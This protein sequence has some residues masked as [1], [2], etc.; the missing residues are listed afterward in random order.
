MHGLYFHVL[1]LGSISLIGMDS[2]DD[3]IRMD[4][5]TLEELERILKNSSLVFETEKLN[6]IT[7]SFASEG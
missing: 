5:S 3:S 7:F 6:F 1:W 2:S 4:S